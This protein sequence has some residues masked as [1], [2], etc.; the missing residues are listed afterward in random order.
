MARRREEELPRLLERGAIE[1]YY[2]PRVETFQPEHIGDVQ[3]LLIVLSAESGDRFR[4]IAVGRKRI[5]AG[6]RRDRFWG[7]VDLVLNAPQ[8]LKAALGAQ[9]Y[10]TKRRGVRHLPAACPAAEGSYT[11]AFH[12]GHAHLQWQ[13]AKIHDEDEVVRDL[14]LEKS[15]DAIVTIANPDPAAW[16]LSDTPPLQLDLFDDAELHVTIPTTFP[17]ELQSR[18]EDRRFVQLESID[19]LNHPGAELVF[20]WSS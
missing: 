19:F 2:R 20:I 5:P 17:P 4:V 16:G 14:G 18:F 1:F 7:F 13:L 9:T 11:I 15:G 8:D 10:G 12:D 6:E 3:R